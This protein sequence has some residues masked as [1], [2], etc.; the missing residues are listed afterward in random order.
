MQCSM[1]GVANVPAVV[2]YPRFV[3]DR[4]PLEVVGHSPATSPAE[5]GSE[6]GR[7]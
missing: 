2:A 6:V 3:A 4:Y 5:A 1:D 7:P